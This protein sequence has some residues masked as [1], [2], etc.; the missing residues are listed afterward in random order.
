[1]KLL[2]IFSLLCTNLQPGTDSTKTEIKK[3]QTSTPKPQ[4]RKH[5][6]GLPFFPFIIDNR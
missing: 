5:K 1:M 3:K 6:A 2:L 4:P